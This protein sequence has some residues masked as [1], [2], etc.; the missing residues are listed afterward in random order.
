MKKYYS[1]LICFIILAVLVQHRYRHLDDDGQLKLTTWDAMGYYMY[2]PSILI[3]ND[4]KQLN[5]VPAVEEQ[6]HVLGN[7]QLYQAGKAP[8]GNYFYKY[9]GG[10]ALLQ[11]P[12][13]TIAHFAAPS[14]GYPPDGFSPPYQ[15]A[16][17]IAALF[18]AMLGIVV[19]RRVL[20]KYF[21]DSI[22]AA[23]LLLTCLATNFVQYAAVDGGQSHIYIFPLYAIVLYTTMR[24]HSRPQ[25]LWALLTGYI[26]G[27]AT[28]CRPTEAVMLFI[29]LFW[30]IHNR[31]SAA[32]KW[33]LVGQHR[34]HILYAVAGGIAGILPQL[35]YWKSATG[36][37]IY[38]VGSA[39]DFLTP[40]FR[41][42]AGWEKGWF[43]Y[44]P[45]TIFFIAGLFFTR[46]YDFHRAVLW[47][48]IL[49][50][51]IVISWRDWQYGG[52]YSTRALVQSYP[53][54]ALSLAAF[55]QHIS[56]K[57]YSWLMYPVGIYLLAVNLFQL[58]QY[59]DTIIHFRDNNRK[60]YAAVYL[61]ADPTPADM[62]LLDNDE[63]LRST[64]GY[65]L[66]QLGSISRDTVIRFAPGGMGVMLDTL[67]QTPQRKQQWLIVKADIYA[68]DGYWNGYLNATL[69][70]GDS[71]KHAR[72]R[73]FRPGSKEREFNKYELH[74]SIPPYFSNS[75]VKVFISRAD[76]HFDGT[77]RQSEVLLATSEE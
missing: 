65:H 3:Y 75:R 30:G 46:R 42:L 33:G 44:T 21:D 59:A 22:V 37:W 51:Y 60:Y 55:I 66:Q 47:F 54:F 14:L 1:L 10:V 40:H 50:I 2:L 45:V 63:I 26:I 67:L 64:N 52:S 48:C 62:S 4:Y 11:L 20:K 41:V 24:W 72:A 18:Y 34:R 29:P 36:T 27:L 70:T 13:F 12:F 69:T 57:K 32:A 5:W 31:E 8:N 77:I 28:I 17:G 38:D 19:L 16:V 53:V 74:M 61:D 71:V 7:G 25:A 73:L 68:W 6:Y 35:L 39:W 23:T 43:I 76:G 56:N 49:N 15:W 58:E 9:L